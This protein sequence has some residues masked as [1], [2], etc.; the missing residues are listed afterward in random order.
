LG[1]AVAVV[2]LAYCSLD[3]GR[4]D[5]RVAVSSVHA[6]DLLLPLGLFLA[7]Q[8]LSGLKWWLVRRSVGLTRPVFEYV[9]YYFIGMVVNVFGVS[10]IGGDV[11]RG[12]YLRGGPPAPPALNPV[13]FDRISALAV[14]TALGA[15]APL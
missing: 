11:V 15:P 14:L 9:R 4:A 2:V 5:P 12:L 3:V 8:V 13:D 6:R 10:T 1:A 7:G